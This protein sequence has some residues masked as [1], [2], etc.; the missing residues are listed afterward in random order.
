MKN[1]SFTPA[2][3]KEIDLVDYLFSLGYTPTKIRSGDYW[4]L[5]PLREEKQASFKVNRKL[6]T[7]YDFGIGK[8]GNLIDF[9]TS[10][11]HCGIAEL[12]DV[13]SGKHLCCHHQEKMEPAS[14]FLERSDGGNDVSSPAEKKISII[15]V[16]N[17]TSNALCRYLRDRRIP[18]AIADHYCKEVSYKINNKSYYAIGFEN[19]SGGYELRNEYFK[20]SNSPKDVRLIENNSAEVVAVFEGFFSFLSYVSI[21]KN[22]QYPPIN[23]LILNSLSLFERSRPLLEKHKSIHLYLDRDKAGREQTRKALTLS[24]RYK[25]RSIMYK[26]YK[27]MND[28]LTRKKMIK[29]HKLY[30]R[31]GL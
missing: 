2:E 3:A 6:N 11:H 12:L 19:N 8:G 15:A 22:E 10:Y 7:W 1:E 5:S 9:G 16:K 29:E 14:N 28:W 23:F 13:L 30:A 20:G 24:N 18:L 25:D 21:G 31:G 26:N 4:Y 17:I 27:D